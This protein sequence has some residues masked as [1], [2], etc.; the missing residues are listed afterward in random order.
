MRVSEHHACACTQNA[1]LEKS[2]LKR[3]VDA[4]IRFHLELDRVYR[5]IVAYGTIRIIRLGGDLLRLP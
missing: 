2:R 3:E 1:L 5:C 4:K